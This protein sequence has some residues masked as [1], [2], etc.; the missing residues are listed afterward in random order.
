MV[1]TAGHIPKEDSDSGLEVEP[2]GVH[3]PLVASRAKAKHA[4]VWECV[5]LWCGY[6]CK[7]IPEVHVK[8]LLQLLST[9]CL[10]AVSY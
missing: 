3:F 7:Q 10:E 1:L 8:C 4:H 5:C 2:K 9:L 6:V